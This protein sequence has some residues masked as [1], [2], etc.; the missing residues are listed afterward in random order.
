MAGLSRSGFY[1][2]HKRP[3]DDEVALLAL[4]ERHQRWGLPKLFKRLR[5]KGKPWN[6]KR[7]ERVYNMLKLNLR[8]KGKRRVPTRA[9]EPLSAPAEH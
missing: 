2:K 1:Y 7:V 6:K 8:R 4:V 3:S 9:P 5:N